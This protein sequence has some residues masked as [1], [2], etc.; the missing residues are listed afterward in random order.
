MNWI[1]VKERLPD[2]KYDGKPFL[3]WNSDNAY[4]IRYFH[5]RGRYVGFDWPGNAYKTTHWISGF[6]PKPP[7]GKS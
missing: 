3:T 7:K 1:K 4:D 5:V 6:L 2:L